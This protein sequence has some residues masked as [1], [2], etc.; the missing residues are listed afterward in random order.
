MAEIVKEEY[1]EEEQKESR[2][3]QP[4]NGEYVAQLHGVEDVLGGPYGPSLKFVFKILEEPYENSTVSGLVNA[5]WKPKNKL[6]KWLVGLG[7]NASKIGTRIDPKSLIGN[8]VRVYVAENKKGYAEV[9]EINP[10]RKK[11]SEVTAPAGTVAGDTAVDRTAQ[12]AASATAPAP[13][14]APVNKN[15]KKDEEVPF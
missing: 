5:K 12:P 2:K 8:Q 7:L 10:L 11:Q 9:K 14:P 13:A 3:N 6:D 15:G 1:T 4:D